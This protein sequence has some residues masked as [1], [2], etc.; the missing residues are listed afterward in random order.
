MHNI[1]YDIDIH[2]LL[3][4]YIKYKKKI[5]RILPI[6]L[7]ILE[8]VSK[9]FERKAKRLQRKSNKFKK[10]RSRKVAQRFAQNDTPGARQAHP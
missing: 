8:I 6:S 10:S 3:Q 9:S 7:A 1:N 5:F 4:R 2:I